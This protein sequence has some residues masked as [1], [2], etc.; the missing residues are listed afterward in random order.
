MRALNIITQT[1][2]KT[3][4]QKLARKAALYGASMAAVTLVAACHGLP[5]KTDETATWTNNK[6]YTEAQDALNGGDF[7]K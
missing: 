4:A 5:E 2:R 1:V 6:L 7:G 3:V